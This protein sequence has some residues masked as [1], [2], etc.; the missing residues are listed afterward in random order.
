MREHC[1]QTLQKLKLLTIVNK[2]KSYTLYLL[3]RREHSLAELKKKLLAKKYLEEEI[4]DLLKELATNNM[5]SDERFVENLVRTRINRG[6]G[7]LRI[8]EELS[9]HQISP[10]L[11]EKYLSLEEDEWIRFAEKTRCKKFGVKKPDV[12]LEEVKQKK[13]LQYKGFNFT[14]INKLFKMHTSV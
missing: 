9:L 10:E 13:Y 8:R 5:Q 7:A 12:L 11:V 6:C 3:A 14:T 1:S 4:S 2:I